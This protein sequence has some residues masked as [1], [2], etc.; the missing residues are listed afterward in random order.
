MRM[1]RGV[2]GRGALLAALGLLMSSTVALAQEPGCERCHGELEL[3]RQNV[4]SLDAARA[5][6]VR[7]AI[8]AASAHGGMACAD[9]HTGFRLYPHTPSATTTA[10]CASC[11]APADSAWAAGVHAGIAD[12]QPV[13]CVSCHGI[14]DVAPAAAVGASSSDPAR[15]VLVARCVA[16]HATDDLPEGNPHRGEVACTACHS[17]HATRPP[18]EPS[19]RLAPAAQAATCGACHADEALLWSTDIHGHAVLSGGSAP[20]GRRG[21]ACTD[22]H[23]AHDMADPGDRGYAAATVDECAG[24]HEAAANTYYGSYHGKAA[25]LGSSVAATCAQCHG[26]HGIL[27]AADP[28]SKVAHGNLV[29]TCGACHEQARP[30]FVLY[31]SHPDPFNRDRN[32]YIYSAFWFMNSLLV[33]VLLVFGAHTLLWWVR[34]EI[35]KRRGIGH[36]AHGGEDAP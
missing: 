23:G 9:C 14:H 1:R 35:D 19:S 17:H 32:P 34:I 2:G 22:C 13:P 18:M 6:L 31:D 20:G 29:E 28:A 11:H 12:G 5:L 26:A 27:P 7:S 3:L 4:P 24:C 10:S 16:C 25:R 36:G 15:G 33:F 21:A 30:A 8:V